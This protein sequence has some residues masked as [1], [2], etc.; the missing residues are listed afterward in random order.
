[1]EHGLG[2]RAQV[3]DPARLGPSPGQ[4]P[5][6]ARAK[7]HPGILQILRIL[8]EC[9]GILRECFQILRE[10]FQILREPF[11]LLQVYFQIL[12]GYFQ[13]RQEYFQILREYFQILQPTQPSKIRT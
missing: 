11:G 8:R 12:W 4:D 5:D 13:I 2:Y 6:W 1:M 10:Y 7:C 3:S 9:F